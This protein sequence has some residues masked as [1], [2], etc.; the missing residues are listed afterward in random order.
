LSSFLLGVSQLTPARLDKEAN[1]LRIESAMQQTAAAG[2]DAILFPELFLT[3]YFLTEKLASMAEP[4]GGPS[5]VRLQELARRYQLLTICGW[6]ETA[7]GSRPYNS[8]VIIERD[9]EVVGAYRKTHLFGR[10]PEFFACGDRLRAFDTSVGR[11]GVLCY[12]MEFPEAARILALDGAAVLLAPTANMNPYSAY[13]AVYTRARAMENGVY[14]A[15]A[16]TVGQLDRFDFFGESSVVDPEGNV[17]EIAGAEERVL[18]VSVDP[19]RVPRS[20]AALRY[21]QHRRPELYGGL[22]QVDLSQSRGRSESR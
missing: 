19:A 13:Q 14:V 21:L 4:L 20:E 2:G 1:L 12:D 15:T 10:E 7:G 22:T 18:M 9:G 17:I 11:I 5:L 16:N 8:A 3:G 6:P